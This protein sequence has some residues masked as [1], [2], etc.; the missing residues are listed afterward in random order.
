MRLTNAFWL[1]FAV[2]AP[3]CQEP[4]QP[5][6]MERTGAEVDRTVEHAQ[7]GVGNFG[8]RVG[9]ALNQAGQS[10]GDAANNAGTSVH[11][12][13]IPADKANPAPAVDPSSDGRDK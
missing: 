7:Q 6:V 11:D 2:A 1:L 3:G 9:R 10:V 5:G 8:L 4:G 13:L 12:W